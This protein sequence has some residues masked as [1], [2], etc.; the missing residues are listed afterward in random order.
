MKFYLALLTFVALFLASTASAMPMK[1][2]EDIKALSM[3]T[4]AEYLEKIDGYRLAIVNHLKFEREEC[5]SKYRLPRRVPRKERKALT[6]KKEQCLNLVNDWKREYFRALSKAKKKY[7]SGVH[8]KEIEMIDK[9]FQEES[10]E[11]ANT[12][13]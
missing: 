2:K 9:A 5:Q 6:E 3:L 4:S 11:T 10:P 12:S 1:L 13:N 7:V 8:A